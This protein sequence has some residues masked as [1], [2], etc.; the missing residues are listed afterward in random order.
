M[1]FLIFLNKHHGYAP[2]GKR[3]P[4]GGGGGPSPAPA[5]AA[6]SNQYSNLSPYIAPYITSVLGAAQQQAFQIDPSTGN[7]SGINPYTAYGMNGAGMSPSAQQAAQSS[8]A[9]FTPLQQQSFQGAGQLQTPGQFG[10]ATGAAAQGTMQA[11]GAGQQYNQMATNPYAVGAYMNPYLSQSLQPQLNQI[12]Q[13]GNIAAQQAQS[14]ATGQGAFGGTRSALASNLAQQNALMAQQ[15]A[16]GQGYNTAY[17][18]AQ[19]SMQY[20]AGLGLQ[21]S[22]AGI[23]GAGQLGQLGTQQLAA[24]QG[25]LGLQNTYGTQQ[26]QGAQDVINQAMQNYQT[27][28]AYPMQQLSQLKSLAQ[29]LP[30]TDV[31]TTQQAAPPTAFGQLAG[32]GLTGLGVAGATGA[33]NSPPVTNVI[34][35][36]SKKGGVIKKYASGGLVDLSL[37]NTLKGAA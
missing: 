24:Q 28:Q 36:A 20:G 13:Q 26:Q 7:I 15:Q 30:M 2:D 34:V 21:G 4:F 3:T 5:P 32:L 12:A 18:Q 25:I 17:N 8:V 14:G 33:F 10:A 31:T 29:G 23:A 16:I 9:G 11:L 22:Q 19:Q 35:P 6:Q 27:A 37:Y 1:S